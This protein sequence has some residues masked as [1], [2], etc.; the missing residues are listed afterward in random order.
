M[1]AE[2]YDVVDFVRRI[3]APK[4]FIFGG[5]DSTVTKGETQSLFAESATPKEMLLLEDAGHVG[6]EKFG[7]LPEMARFISTNTNI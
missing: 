7:L 3:K 2:R 5:K 6:M 1:W 4:L